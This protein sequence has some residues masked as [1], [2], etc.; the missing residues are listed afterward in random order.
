MRSDLLVLVGEEELE[1]VAAGDHG[2]PAHTGHPALQA[3]HAHLDELLL[4]PAWG[5]DRVSE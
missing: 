3:L 2:V 1:D 4:E 5:A